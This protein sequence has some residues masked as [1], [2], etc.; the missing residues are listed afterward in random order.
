MFLV[1]LLLLK[2][3]QC[4]YAWRIESQCAPMANTLS[5]RRFFLLFGLFDYLFRLPFSTTTNSKFIVYY[6][7]FRNLLVSGRLSYYDII[8]IIRGYHLLNDFYFHKPNGQYSR[9]IQARI[10]SNNVHW[11][12]NQN[13]SQR[14]S[15]SKSP[16]IDWI[17]Y[18]G[19]TI[20]GIGI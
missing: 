14:N 4:S 16:V 2:S 17:G 8:R 6:I 15:I 20:C 7:W 11:H 1:N 10:I 9:H 5:F 13:E 12:Q 18:Y 19:I 3:T